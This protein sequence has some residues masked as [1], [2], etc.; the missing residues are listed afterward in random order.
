ML[1][2]L[3][4]E[5]L[6]LCLI[7]WPIAYKEGTG[8]IFPK[9]KEGK[10]QY[11]G[12]DFME[13]WKAMEAKAREGKIRSLGLSNFAEHQIDRVLAEGEINPA[14]LQVEMN[15]YLQQPE[16]LQ[17][18]EEK[19]I[20]ITAY[21]PLG[22]AAQPMRNGNQPLLLNDSTLKEIA[23]A[24]G[25]SVAQVAIRFLLQR[26]VAVIPKSI[27]EKRI[28]ENFSVFDFNL[29][30]FEM[31]KIAALDK[32]LRICDAKNRG[33]DTHPDYPWPN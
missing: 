3:K 4:L 27:S 1:K 14:V 32:N 29:S 19:G 26:G 5:Y 25:K 30:D 31:A 16:L 11:S 10:L 2:D 21:S 18:C 20:V 23:E 17:F 9:N 8:E 24:H 22:N 6:D 33:D 7:H 12:I 13:T 15:V 28:K